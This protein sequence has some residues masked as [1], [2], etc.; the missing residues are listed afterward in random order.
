LAGIKPAAAYKKTSRLRVR[1]VSKI[2]QESLSSSLAVFYVEQVA[3]NRHEVDVKGQGECLYSTPG[4]P[5]QYPF[6]HPTHQSVH[7]LL[8]IGN[9]YLKIRGFIDILARQ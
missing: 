2:I 1:E 4:S 6:T 3:L 7:C 8:V 9:K 5:G